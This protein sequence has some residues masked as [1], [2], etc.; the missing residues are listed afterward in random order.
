MGQQ[1]REAGEKFPLRR[2]VREAVIEADIEHKGFASGMTD[3]PQITGRVASEKRLRKVPDF[4]G[5][6]E[7]PEERMRNRERLPE[8]T[9]PDRIFHQF[10]EE[11]VRI[12]VKPL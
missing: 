6:R 10:G 1:V 12:V 11:G 4:T 7:T 3:G 5:E 9:S 2:C 8:L